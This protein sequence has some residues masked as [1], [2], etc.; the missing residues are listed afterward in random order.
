VTLTEVVGYV[1]A[2]LV[3]L[4]FSMRTMV[5]LRAVGILS[6]VFFVAYGYLSGAYPIMVLHAILLPLNSFRLYQIVALLRKVEDAGQAGFDVDWLKS[7]ATP[8]S[9]ARGEFL[10]RKGDTADR[11]AYIVSGTFKVVGLGHEIGKGQLTGELG[12]LAPTK[13]RTQTLEC[14]AEAEVLELTYEQVKLLYFQSPRF[15][16]YLLQ[17]AGGRREVFL[18]AGDRRRTSD[19]GT[20]ILRRQIYST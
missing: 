8:R 4:T 5:H 14:V 6:N 15:A 2:F 12:L 18:A 9:F 1:A 20:N 16:L 11:M 19:C 3:L 13:T 17:L 7:I 10:F